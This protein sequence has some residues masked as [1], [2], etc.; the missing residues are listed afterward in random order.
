M[1]VMR[2]ASLWAVLL[3]AAPAMAQGGLEAVAGKTYAPGPFNSLYFTGAAT[4]RFLQ[5]DRDEVF[6]EGDSQAQDAVEI[7]LEGTRL[8]VRSS[9]S[10]KF[11]RGPQQRTRM[12]VVAKDLRSIKV[13]GAANF[14]APETLR[15]TQLQ[16][17]ISGAAVARFDKL[18]TERLVFAVSGA[19][20]GYFTGHAQIVTV[21]ITGKGDF[22]GADLESQQAK[23]NI[24]GL[25]KARLWV[26]KTLDANIS[27]IGTIEYFGTPVVHQ[28][29][30]GM[31]RYNERGPRPPAVPTPPLPLPSPPSP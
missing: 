14:L 8:V 20:D 22:Y 31:G 11:W 10:W 2:F 7:G 29:N 25:G 9:G 13:S 26:H 6:V 27:G 15:L 16:V 21:N 23:V 28:K 30:T 18:H 19:G 24:S 17:D 12:V 5:G 4:V 3:A 1:S